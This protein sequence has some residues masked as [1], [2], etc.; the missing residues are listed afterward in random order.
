MLG[1]FKDLTLDLGRLG[2]IGLPLGF[3]VAHSLLAIP[4]VVI[5]LSAAL[6]GVDVTLE[7][8]SM[9]LGASRLTTLR[10]VVFPQVLPAMVAS[11]FFAFLV[12]WDELIIALFLSR[13]ETITLPKR[14]WEGIRL[15]VNPAITA[16]ATMLIFLT[17][18]MLAAIVLSQWYFA[19][20]RRL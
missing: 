12:S 15:D 3:V 16:I 18:L 14:I 7:Q 5:I 13:T 6:R 1:N 8:A 20:R 19:R 10:R 4:Y 11:A 2:E 9:S 17:I